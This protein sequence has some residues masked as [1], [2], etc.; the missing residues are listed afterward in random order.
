[1]IINDLTCFIKLKCAKFKELTVTS[2]YR[3]RQ[4]K[5]EEMMLK[6]Y[7]GMMLKRRELGKNYYSN[8]MIKKVID[9]PRL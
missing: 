8:H 7:P 6:K 4:F 9:T 5:S 3:I 1:M 2:M